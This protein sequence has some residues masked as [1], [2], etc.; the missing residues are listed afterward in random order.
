ME[1]KAVME[2]MMVDQKVKDK[3]RRLS[4]ISGIDIDELGCKLI[5][6]AVEAEIRNWKNNIDQVP[7][8]YRRLLMID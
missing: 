8:K 2:R 1:A 3:M 7:P 4:V 5:A 6:S